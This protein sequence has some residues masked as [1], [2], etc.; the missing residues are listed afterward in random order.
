MLGPDRPYRRYIA[1]QSTALNTTIMVGSLELGGYKPVLFIVRQN[2][3]QAFLQRKF[4]VTLRHHC[5][6]KLI[7]QEDMGLS[8]LLRRFYEAV[9]DV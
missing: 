9:L 3:T 4:P 6:W 1:C 2:V 8:G 7:D 5:Q